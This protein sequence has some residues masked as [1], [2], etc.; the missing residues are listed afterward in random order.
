MAALGSQAHAIEHVGSTS[1]ASLAAKPIADIC[2]IVD[3]SSDEASYVPDLEQA[4]YVLR[5]R[6][7]E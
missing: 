3:D 5:V 1:V 4:G 2:V 6:E 7:P